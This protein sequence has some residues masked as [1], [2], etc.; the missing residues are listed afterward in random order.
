MCIHFFE[1]DVISQQLDYHKHPCAVDMATEWYSQN[2]SI[3]CHYWTTLLQHELKPIMKVMRMASGRG[4]SH[5]NG[6]DFLQPFKE[7]MDLLKY[8]MNVNT[9]DSYYPAETEEFRDKMS[10]LPAC[11]YSSKSK[12]IGIHCKLFEPV[13]TDLG[14]CYSFNAEPSMNMLK[15]SSFTEAF[16]EAYRYDLIEHSNQHANGA[17]DD[18]SLRFMIENS[19]YLRQKSETKPFK[20]VIS[21]SKGYFDAHSVA[22]EINPG[23]ETTFDIQPLEVIGTDE[24]HRIDEQARNCRFSDEVEEKSMFKVYSQSSCE[25]ECHINIAREKCNCTPWNHP[26][27]PTLHNSIVCD[28]YG[29]SCFRSKMTEARVIKKCSKMCPSDCDD[30]RFSINKQ[31]VPINLASYCGDSEHDGSQLTKELFYS[32][33]SHYLPDFYPLVHNYYTMDQNIATNKTSTFEP[34]VQNWKKPCYDI[35]SNDIAVVKVRLE[36]SKYLRTV[37]DKRL[38]FADKL[39]SFGKALNFR[40]N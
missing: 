1:S 20:L 40:S 12:M 14:I 4:Q 39:A 38:S 18:F 25:Y 10:F 30:V 28:L 19:R 15:N 23:Y 17:G 3:C 24:L 34:V 37:K 31:V 22:K 9:K 16:Q 11:I 29:N 33:G 7:K 8:P 6:T 26:H 21:A 32:D 27:P 35:M 36:T 5:F 2:K 13:V